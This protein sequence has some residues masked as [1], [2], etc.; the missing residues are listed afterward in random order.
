MFS[1]TDFLDP[2]TQA[3]FD[4]DADYMKMPSNEERIKVSLPFVF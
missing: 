1:I 4:I 2:A 3:P